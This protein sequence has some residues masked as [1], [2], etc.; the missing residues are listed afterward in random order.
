MLSGTVFAL[1]SLMLVSSGGSQAADVT[2]IYTSTISGEGYFDSTYPADFTYDAKLTL[3]PGGSGSLWLECTDVVVNVAGW[4]AALDAIGQSQT[5]DVDYTVLGSSVTLTIHDNYGGSYVLPVTLDGDRLSG[6]GQYT[7]ISQVTNSWQMDVTRGGGGSTSLGFS[8]IAG[9]AGAVAIGG[10]LVGFAVS[11]LPPPRYMGGSI[12]PPSQTTLGTPYA[13]SQS[14][15]LDHRMSSMANQPGGVT[16]PLSDVPRMRMQ[17]DPIQFQNV[18]M[19][20]ATDV[21]PTEVHRTDV[22]SKRTCP[23]CGSTLMVTAAGWSCPSCNRAPP[24]GLDE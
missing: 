19:G 15:V 10:F 14:L 8:G 24:G 21:R 17:F 5:V 13:P 20:K 16:R 9:I 3:D 7:D 11:S 1:L 6:S 18:E 4:E 23:N 22:L 2:G 12:M